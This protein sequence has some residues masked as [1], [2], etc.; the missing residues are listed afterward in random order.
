MSD[1]KQINYAYIVLREHDGTVS[2][3]VDNEDIKLTDF[4]NMA[5]QPTPGDVLSD[6]SL[7]DTDIKGLLLTNKLLQIF[8]Q[9]QQE[10]E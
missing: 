7:I 4:F 2:T 8:A 1:K 10:Q 3:F 5:K 6:M 9:Q